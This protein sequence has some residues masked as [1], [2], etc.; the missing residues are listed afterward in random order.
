MTSDGSNITIIFEDGTTEFRQAMA[1]VLV[2][3]P[4]STS[5]WTACIAIKPGSLVRMSNGEWKAVLKL[6]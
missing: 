6:T 1:M 2:R 3:G 4:D 5:V